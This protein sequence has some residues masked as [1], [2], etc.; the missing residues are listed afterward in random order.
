MCLLLRHLESGFAPS[1]RYTTCKSFL[2]HVGHPKHPGLLN[3][4][5]TL[6]APLSLWRRC[7][8]AYY[9]TVDLSQPRTVAN[10]S[11]PDHTLDLRAHPW[12]DVLLVCLVGVCAV[13]VPEVRFLGSQAVIGPLRETFSKNLLRWWARVC[14]RALFLPVYLFICQ[15][16]FS[17]S[18]QLLCGFVPFPMPVRRSP[19]LGERCFPPALVRFRDTIVILIYFFFK[20]IVILIICYLTLTLHSLFFLFFFVF[21]NYSADYFEKRCPLSEGANH[22]SPTWK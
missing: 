17:V 21:L 2:P 16:T 8:L 5:E 14:Q 3:P 4:A 19:W 9:H 7:T 20:K 11:V 22:R 12:L 13:Q 18:M 10:D 1:Q 15:C 6:L